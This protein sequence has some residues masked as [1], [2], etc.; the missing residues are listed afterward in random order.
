MKNK[1]L[2]VIL[3]LLSFSLTSCWNNNENKTNNTK[4]NNEK[5][6]DMKTDSVKAAIWWEA[7]E[8]E[9]NFKETSEIINTSEKWKEFDKKNTDVEVKWK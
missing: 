2:I 1:I 3:I 8:K 5:K 4:V 7:N 9:N 6:L